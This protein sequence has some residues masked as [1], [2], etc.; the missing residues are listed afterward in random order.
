MN[1]YIQYN[2]NPKRSRVGDCVIRAISKATGKSWDEVYKDLS[3]EGYALADMPNANNV[4]GS[5]L[6]KL[7]F[8]RGIISDNCPDCYTVS[9][10]VTE[11]PRGTYILALSSHAV[12]VVDGEYFDTW[13]SG[14]EVPLYYWVKTGG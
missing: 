7:G 3:A 12:A 10:F 1:G 6:R 8:K 11:N 14:D 4:W 13:D 5:Y 9:D 2:A